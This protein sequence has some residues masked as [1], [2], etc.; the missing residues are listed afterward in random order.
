MIWM[1]LFLYNSNMLQ[2][3]QFEL[4]ETDILMFVIYFYIKILYF[5]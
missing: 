5:V 2:L 4:Q 3:S 1:E